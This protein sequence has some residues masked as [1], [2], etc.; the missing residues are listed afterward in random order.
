MHSMTSGSLYSDLD[1]YDLVL[2]CQKR[3]RPRL[4]FYIEG[5]RVLSVEC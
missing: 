4:M 1:D 3:L 2:A 5:T